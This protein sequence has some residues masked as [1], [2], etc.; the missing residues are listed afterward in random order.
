MQCEN[1]EELGRK[2]GITA[3]TIGAHK[4]EIKRLASLEDVSVAVSVTTRRLS[5]LVQP[6]LRVR[7]PE[8]GVVGEMLW[9]PP[10]ASAGAVKAEASTEV[11]VVEKVLP[12]VPHGTGEFVRQWGIKGSGDADEPARPMDLAVWGGEVF[13]CDQTNECI[14]VFTLDGTFL[15]QWGEHGLGEGKF[16]CPFN[17]A[18]SDG[19]VFVSD[20][21]TS[22]IQVFRVDG[23]FLRQW[24]ERGSGEGQFHYPRGMAVSGMEVFVCDSGNHRIQVFG[25]DGSFVRQ[26][27]QEGAG[28]GQL[29]RPC[30]VAVH[31]MK[32]FVSEKNTARIQVFGLDGSFERQWG[33]KVSKVDN[34][35][36]Y[37]AVSGRE[38]F[39]SDTDTKCIQV[40]TSDGSYTRHWDFQKSGH[41]NQGVAGVE[42]CSC[43]TPTA[44]SG[45]LTDVTIIIGGRIALL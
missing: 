40:F 6:G 16:Y 10:S 44:V 35:W 41:R 13:V 28:E 27:G 36:T 2:Y 23:S 5:L 26:W 17:L 31:G 9:S 25:L 3:T 34:S 42:K 15:R 37:V 11:L 18:L 39:L 24:G 32:V 29:T 43:V 4:R 22:L 7:L 1:L 30:G 12:I 19:E 20:F 14:K 33:T 21:A 38:V 45:S 8:L